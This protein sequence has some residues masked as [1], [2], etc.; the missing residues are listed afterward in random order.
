MSFSRWFRKKDIVLDC[1]TSNPFAYN[2]ARIN[3][4][5]HYIPEWWKKTPKEISPDVHSNDPHRRTIKK[6]PGLINYYKKSI[7]IP[8]WTDLKLILYAKG[9]DSSFEWITSHDEFFATGHDQIQ[10]EEFAGQEGY[11]LK[12]PSPWLIHCRESAEF[13]TSQPT[14]SQ[15]N[16][17]FDLQLL[18]GILEFKTQTNTQMN[19][20]FERREQRVELNLEPL[21]PMMMLHPLTD[22][23]VVLKHHYVHDNDKFFK[24]MATDFGMF[25]DKKN[26]S[27][28][29]KKKR[30]LID[31]ADKLN[32]GEWKF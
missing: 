18:P 15:R 23:K 13:M 14:W 11:N 22:R 1:Y 4:G 31:K 19:Y 32:K 21:T 2:F 30:N 10:F 12:I 25:N 17:M 28:I 29:Y 16:S 7:V 8:L 3:Y 6:C 27:N 26:R 5:Y 20:F 9:E 24:M